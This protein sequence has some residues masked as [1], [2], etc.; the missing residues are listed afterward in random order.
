MG[1]LDEAGLCKGVFAIG[2]DDKAIHRT[3]AIY[4]VSE[5]TVPSTRK[6]ARLCLE[7]KRIKTTAL[8]S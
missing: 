7:L 4:S 5:K 2:S 6:H 8:G 3:S 1:R